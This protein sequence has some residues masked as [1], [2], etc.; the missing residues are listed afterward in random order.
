[1][2]QFK[3]DRIEPVKVPRIQKAANAIKPYAN[4]RNLSFAGIVFSG[5]YLGFFDKENHYKHD[6]YIFGNEMK[7][8]IINSHNSLIN[9]N[10]KA[11]VTKADSA[12]AKCARYIE[13]LADSVKRIRK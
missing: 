8:K 7:N 5:V 9:A 11:A 1:M 10:D 6:Q 12:M 3:L 4:I 13:F 2:V